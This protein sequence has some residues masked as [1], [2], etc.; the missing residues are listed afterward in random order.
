MASVICGALLRSLPYHSSYNVSE[1]SL[2]RV[3][4]CSDP[5]LSVPIA[6]ASGVTRS[7]SHHSVRVYWVPTT[8][9]SLPP[10]LW[11]MNEKSS[12]CPPS[13]RDEVRSS[14]TVASQRKTG[15]KGSALRSAWA[16]ALMSLIT[17]V[18]RV[19]R[20]RSVQLLTL[21]HS[22]YNAYSLSSHR[23]S[24]PDNCEGHF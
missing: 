6:Q 15:E 9:S 18:G 21:K 10:V 17:S 14:H 7:R 22:L 19:P 12:L 23:Q 5:A 24:L 4:C 1:G 20:G 13:W 3:F 2:F 8:R 11:E 16:W